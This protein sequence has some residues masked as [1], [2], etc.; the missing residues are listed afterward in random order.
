MLGIGLIGAILGGATIRALRSRVSTGQ[1]GMV[2]RVGQTVM[3][4]HDFIDGQGYVRLDGELWK[5]ISPDKEK[6]FAG[7]RLMIKSI[8]GLEITIKKIDQ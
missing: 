4:H 8:I 5:A 2:D 1:Q 6:I 7:D 3:A